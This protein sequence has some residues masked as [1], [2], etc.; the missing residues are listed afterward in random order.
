MT[1]PLRFP[2]AIKISKTTSNRVLF[3]VNKRTI[4]EILGSL[5][6]NQR[7]TIQNLRVLI[8]NSVPEIVELVKNG[9]ITYKL[10]E[11]DFVWISHFQDHVDLEFA[12]G[13]SLASKVLKSRG[14]AES[15]NNVRHVAVGNFDKLKPELSRLINEAAKLGFEH[16]PIK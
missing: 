3:T 9:K 10:G 15:N 5:Q 12:M 11:K 8:K 1:Y 13:A 14:V 6:P 2:Q 4:D 16:C 7:E